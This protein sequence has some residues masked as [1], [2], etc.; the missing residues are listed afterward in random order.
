MPDETVEKVETELNTTNLSELK[1]T[2][3]Q[4]VNSKKYRIRKDLVTALLD[5]NKLYSFDEVDDLIVKFLKK[6]VN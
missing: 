3:S 6:E 1:F 4:I 2:K 5:E